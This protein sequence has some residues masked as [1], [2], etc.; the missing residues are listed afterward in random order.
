MNIIL[1][2]E[3]NFPCLSLDLPSSWGECNFFDC[4]VNVWMLRGWF[5]W[6]CLNVFYH[7]KNVT[8]QTNVNACQRLLVDYITFFHVFY[9][10]YNS[11]QNTGLMRSLYVCIFFLYFECAAGHDNFL[12]NERWSMRGVNETII[13]NWDIW[14][15]LTRSHLRHSLE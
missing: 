4:V 12:L 14:M 11:S 3:M 15:R 7:R 9:F 2:Y 6:L 1:E 5:I 8:Q 10:E 13:I